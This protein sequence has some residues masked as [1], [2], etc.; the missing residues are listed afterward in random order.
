MLPWELEDWL[1]EEGGEVV[2]KSVALG[3]FS[4]SPDERLLYEVWLFD[5]EARNG[6]VSQ[7]FCNNGNEQWGTL[8]A[9]AMS[10]L[11][12]FPAFADSVNQVVAGQL[13]PYEA[14]IE[15]G[16]ALDDAYEAVQARLVSELKAHLR[17]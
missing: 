15:S 3:Y 16:D 8:C 10:T 13:D 12:S 6:G 1:T 11:P 4:L 7:Y 2:E 17:Q 9:A 5:T 14:V